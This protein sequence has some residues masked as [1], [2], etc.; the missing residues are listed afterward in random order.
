MRD[1]FSVSAGSTY[2]VDE[3]GNQASH[4]HDYTAAGQ[5]HTLPAGT[6]VAASGFGRF[7]LTDNPVTTG[8]TNTIAPVAPW[9]ALAYI[10]FKGEV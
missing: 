5:S 3:T 6:D 9:Y 10:Q 4:D 2:A 8:S 7:N 1:R